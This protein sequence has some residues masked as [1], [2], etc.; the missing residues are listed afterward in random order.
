MVGVLG[1]P[2]VSGDII[3]GED[4][5]DIFLGPEINARKKLESSKP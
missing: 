1:G 4:V 5:L 2:D 3:P